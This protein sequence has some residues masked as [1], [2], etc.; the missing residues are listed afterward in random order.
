MIIV[1]NVFKVCSKLT[2]EAYLEL[3][4]TSTMELFGENS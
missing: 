3:N 2:T 4:R 1:L